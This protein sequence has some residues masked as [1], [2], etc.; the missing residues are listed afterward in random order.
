MAVSSEAGEELELRSILVV[1]S[2]SNYN[3][4][5]LTDSAPDSRIDS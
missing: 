3:G 2:G 5:A 4:N 1:I